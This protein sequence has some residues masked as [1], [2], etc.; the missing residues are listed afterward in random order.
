MPVRVVLIPGMGADHRL[1][2]GI[3]LPGHEV[4][5]TDWIPHREGERLSVYAGRFADHY[6]PCSD[7]MGWWIH[8]RSFSPFG[9]TRTTARAWLAP[10]C[11]R[12]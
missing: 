11:W 6:G 4:L 3:G 2:D 1:F 7:A 9:M 12:S 5:R 8:C 10:S